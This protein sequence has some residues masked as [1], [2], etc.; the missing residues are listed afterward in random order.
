M[1]FIAYGLNHTTAP[2]EV[3]EKYALEMD[4]AVAL[5]RALKTQAA[6]GVFLSTCNRVEFY[7]AAETVEGAVGEAHKALS[8]IHRLKPADVKK[9]FYL[10]EDADAFSHLF[11]VASSLDSMVLGEAQILGQVKE[12]YEGSKEAGMTGTLLNGIF[13]RAFSAAKRVRSQTDIAR[14]PTNVSSVAVDLAKKIFRSLGE[15]AVLVLGAGEMSELT[16]QYLVDNGVRQ[17]YVANR[18]L[19]K[20]RILAS[21]LGGIALNFEEGIKKIA[22]VDIVLTSIGGGLALKKDEIE[23]RIKSRNGRSLFII[24]M[25]V[26]RNVDPEVG[27][28]ESVY[29]YNVDNLSA[30]ASENKSGRQKAVEAA[31][32]ILQE[33]VDKLCSWLVSLELVPTIMRLRERYESIREAEYRDFVSQFPHLTEKEKK[34]VE[35]LTRDITLKVL[36]EPTVNLKKVES[37][38]DRFEFARMLHEIFSLKDNHDND[39]KT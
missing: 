13:A 38:V 27:Q 11:R 39:R 14:M 32:A 21:K 7:L 10:Y 33:E 24:D 31:E 18:T 6:E 19:D 8:T 20:A 22:E 12:A 5:L 3:R 29:L 23:K 35:R 26:P 4:K 25:G 16:A 36:H 17:F 15:N 2:I 34:A 28:M 9:Y 1:K 37:K 30:I